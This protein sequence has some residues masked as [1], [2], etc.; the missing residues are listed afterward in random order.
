MCKCILVP[1]RGGGPDPL[2]PPL[3]PPL[4]VSDMPS[5]VVPFC[6]QNGTTALHFAA[7]NG[8]SAIVRLLLG[9]G[10]TDTSNQ[11]V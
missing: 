10:A 8:H 3:Y 4:V 9:A 2:D 11:V 6:P 7:E 1:E 5:V